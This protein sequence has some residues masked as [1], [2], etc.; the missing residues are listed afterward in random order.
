MLKF[1]INKRKFN[2]EWRGKIIKIVAWALNEKGSKMTGLSTDKFSIKP[3]IKI[4]KSGGL[5]RAGY[6][7]RE[8]AAMFGV[9]EWNV[10]MAIKERQIRVLN[11]GRRQIIPR[12]EIA[13][14]IA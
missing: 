10:R 8:F 11:F 9:S 14:L 5:E 3:E 6:S 2:D 1:L 7:V 13:R 4:N 12:T